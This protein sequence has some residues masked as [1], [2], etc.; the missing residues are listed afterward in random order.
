MKDTA[1]PRKP[2]SRLKLLGQE[3]ELAQLDVQGRRQSA[4]VLEVL[5]GLRT[6]QQAAQ[7]LSLSLPTYFNLETRALRGLVFACCA[8][9]PG[10]Q[11]TLVPQLRQAQAKVA[12][13]QRQV[14]RYQALLRTARQG[15]GLAPAAEVKPLPGSK[16]KVKK[17]SV[18]AI[19]AIKALNQADAA[20]APVVDTPVIATAVVAPATV[21]AAAA[22]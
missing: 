18:R 19:R 12:D 6:P 4:A 1:N 9:P 14:G 2:T 13:L 16:R 5:A 22:G 3:L 17:P 7:A 21:P 15:V 20:S 11:K 8:Q 10:R